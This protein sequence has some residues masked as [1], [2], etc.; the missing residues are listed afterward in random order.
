MTEFEYT[1]SKKKFY[2]HFSLNSRKSLSIKDLGR[3][4]PPKSLTV[5]HLHGSGFRHKKLPSEEGSQQ[6]DQLLVS[7]FAIDAFL[8]C[9]VDRATCYAYAYAFGPSGRQTWIGSLLRW[10]A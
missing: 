4:G 8:I 6:Y 7:L 9:K 10:L 5:S 3:P 1:A 2:V